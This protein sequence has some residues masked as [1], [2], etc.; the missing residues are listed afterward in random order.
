[1]VSQVYPSEIQLNSNT[2]NIEASFVDFKQHLYISNDIVS[3]KNYNERDE[4]D[5]E[6]VNFPFLNG[7]VPLTTSYGYFNS[8]DLLKHL[9]MLM[10]STLAINCLLRNF[11]NK[12]IGI[13]NFTKLFL[14]SIDNTLISYLN[15]MSDSLA[16]LTLALWRLTKLIKE[17]C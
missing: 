12:A 16:P 17:I 3:A 8:S 15:T 7:D 4:F 6:I 14:N 10:T 2:A 9:A 11:L 5:F 1:M 13:I